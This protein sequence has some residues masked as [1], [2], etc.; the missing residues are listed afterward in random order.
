MAIIYKEDV[1]DFDLET[2]NTNRSFSHKILGEGDIK[3][4]RFGIRITRNGEE[5]NMTGVSVIGYF[6]N[7]N[8][9]TEVINGERSGSKCWVELPEA[10]YTVEGKFTLSIKISDGTT[11]TTVRIIDG[12]IEN[13]AV[14]TAYDPGQVIPNLEDFEELV[15]R[16]EEAAE[17]IE[18]INITNTL[19][20]GT[21]YRINVT[22]S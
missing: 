16:V 7:A 5:I 9:D 22:T 19:I 1:I 15:E 17:T 21:R 13:T 3:G 14:G 6:I 4:N 11:I 2:G 18:G 10:C 8:G 20:S 12:T